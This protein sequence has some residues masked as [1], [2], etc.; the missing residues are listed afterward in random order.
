MTTR[1][2]SRFMDNL[3]NEY[4]GQGPFGPPS[5]AP[6]VLIESDK[7]LLCD[8]FIGSHMILLLSATDSIVLEAPA[9]IVAPTVN[10]VAK[11]A[12]ELGMKDRQSQPVPVQLY[13]PQILS[14]TTKHLSVGEIKFLVE[15]ENAFV[16][17]EKLTLLKFTEEDPDYFEVVKSWSIN[18]RMET[19]VLSAPLEQLPLS[20]VR[21]P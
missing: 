14:I 18:D 10:I 12:L 1:L 2:S 5:R 7:S 19:E 17:C 15:P 21:H 9:F 20:G 6:D 3:K 8:G 16:S 4:L 11:R 13:V